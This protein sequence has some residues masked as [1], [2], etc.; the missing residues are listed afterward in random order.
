MKYMLLLYANPADA[1]HYSPEEAQAARQSWFDLVAE[2][3][4]AGVYLH[5]YGLNPVS[6]ATTV[7]VRNGK[8]IVT[9]GPFAATQEH[10]GGYFMLECKDVVEAQRWAAKIPYAGNGSIEVRPVIAY[11]PEMAEAQPSGSAA[12]VGKG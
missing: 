12:G 10:F 7:R 6:D 8:P 9:V 2:M 3:K 4:A 1:P 11:T 5:N